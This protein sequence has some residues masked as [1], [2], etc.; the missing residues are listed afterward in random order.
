MFRWAVHVGLPAYR[1]R[2]NRL[3][4][5]AFEK[6]KNAPLATLPGHER[7]EIGLDE[8][9]RAQQLRAVASARAR[10]ELDVNFHE[11]QR[12]YLERRRL[13]TPMVPVARTDGA[14]RHFFA[15]QVRKVAP[16]LEDELLGAAAQQRLELVGRGA[17]GGK[18][19]KAT[20][21]PLK[22]PLGAGSS[23]GGGTA[24]RSAQ[25]GDRSGRSSGRQSNGGLS[26]GRL[27]NG[28]PSSTRR[29]VEDRGVDLERGETP[30][31]LPFL[32]LFCLPRR[33]RVD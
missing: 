18:G 10:A 7:P 1:A 12:A 3:E 22:G 17:N 9:E 33:R 24:T 13:K 15:A 8:E 28:A 19:G 23:L 32:S 16:D 25:G 11:H 14:A 20:L 30:Q 26:S 6:A 4:R 2:R 31:A 5:A 27:S 29:R 21:P